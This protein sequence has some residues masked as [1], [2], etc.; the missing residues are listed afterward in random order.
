[1]FEKG[2]FND[3]LQIFESLENYKDSTRQA[4]LCRDN[5]REDDYFAA[6]N[7]YETGNYSEAVSA[8]GDLDDSQDSKEYIGECEVA[9]INTSNTNEIVTLGVYNG[10]PIEWLVLSRD[11]SSVL[12]ISKYYVTSKIANENDRGEYGE[13]MC[14]SGSTLRTWLNKDFIDEVF[15]GNVAELLLPNTIQNDEYDVPKITMGGA[16]LKLL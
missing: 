16:K 9:L 4:E 14:W 15:L 1:M 2:E 11:E 13:Y 10:N 8:F 3:S 6:I 12:L 7:L 5:I